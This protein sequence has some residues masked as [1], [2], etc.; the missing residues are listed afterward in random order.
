M[1][2]RTVATC[3]VLVLLA[4]ACGNAGSGKGTATVTTTPGAAP[5]TEVSGAQLQKKVPLPGV[6]GVTDSQINVAVITAGSNPLAGDYTTYE[7]GI[8]A[9][10][11]MVNAS[12]GIYGRKLAV[13][14]SHNDQFIN[15][16]QTVKS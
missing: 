16:Q 4:A 9:S 2:S 10:F 15:N 14:A 12:G 13:T 1:R 8:R 6:Q 5:I 3:I 7:T 11:N